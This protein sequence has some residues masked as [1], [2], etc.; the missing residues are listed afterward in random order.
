[1]AKLKI[2]VY[3]TDQAKPETVVTIPPPDLLGK[4]YIGVEE[5][6]Q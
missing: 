2:K 3:K 6:R 4:D 5:N 1:M